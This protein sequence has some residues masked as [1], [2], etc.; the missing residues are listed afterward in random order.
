MEFSSI[1]STILVGIVY[2]NIRV[3]V[4]LVVLHGFGD[5]VWKLTRADFGK[6]R[7]MICASL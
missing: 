2:G 4:V 7:V 5:T 1:I 6:D 3:L